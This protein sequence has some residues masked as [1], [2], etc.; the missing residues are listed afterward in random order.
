MKKMTEPMRKASSGF[1]TLLASSLDAAK[2]DLG[3]E[4]P[5]C[6]LAFLPSLPL[7]VL[8]VSCSLSQEPSQ[9]PVAQPQ[10]S[11][12]ATNPVPVQD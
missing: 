5:Q 2:V 6:N 3:Q 7:V 11:V 1:S 9:E 12:T 4:K 10:A 8:P